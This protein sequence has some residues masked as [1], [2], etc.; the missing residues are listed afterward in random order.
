MFMDSGTSISEF[1]GRKKTIFS[2]EFS[3]P[4]MTLGEKM[5][6]TAKLLK[7]YKPDFVSITYGAGG[8]TRKQLFTMH[9][10]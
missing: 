5:L 3:L 6:N 8:G 2:L 7:P 4:K 10:F 1:F 9:V